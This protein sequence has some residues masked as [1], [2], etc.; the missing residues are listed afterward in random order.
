VPRARGQASK[1]LLDAEAYRLQVLALAQ[2]ETS[3]FDQVLAQYEHA[4][5]VTRERMYLETME[6]V[7]KNS[8]KVIVDAKTGGSIMYLPLDKLIS[9]GRES[10]A[11]PNDTMTV[12]PARLPEI[13]VTPAEDPARARGVR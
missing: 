13:Q 11:M 8:R 12:A 4:P 10:V 6:N 5:A 7:Y 3:R 9:L 2:G 1:N